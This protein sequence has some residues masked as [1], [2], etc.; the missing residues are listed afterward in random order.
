MH[1]VDV[2]SQILEENSRLAEINRK[3]FAEQNIYVANFMSAPG[4]G[5]TTL[6]EKTIKKMQHLFKI[7]VIEGDLQTDLDA[8]RI[9]NL[10]V[11][12][13][14]ITTGTVC[15]LDARM[16]H[17]ALHEFDIIGQELLFIENVGNLVCPADFDLG[18]NLKVMIFSVV[19]GADKPQKYPVMFHNVDAVILN[20]MDLIEYSDV[21]L[22][23]LIQ[24]IREINTVAPIFPVSCKDGSGID[25]WVNWLSTKIK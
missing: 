10:N 19:E 23:N 24:N 5:K 7:S 6:L 17:N 18:E 21:D 25:D 3:M 4:A 8:E 22:D 12:A 1:I 15:H 16:V 2:N 20:K 9:K 14:Q 13:H 11:P